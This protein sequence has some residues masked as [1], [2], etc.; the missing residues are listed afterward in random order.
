MKE[1]ALV[2]RD[3]SHGHWIGQEAQCRPQPC[4]R[5]PRETCSASPNHLEP[6]SWYSS[7]A[8]TGLVGS[9]PKL[10]KEEEMS[11]ISRPIVSRLVS[12]VHGFL[13]LMN[14]LEGRKLASGVVSS[15]PPVTRG[16]IPGFPD[17][18]SS[19]PPSQERGCQNSGSGNKQKINNL[20]FNSNYEEIS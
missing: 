4:T 20:H 1:Q 14:H 17:V 16:K 13:S 11:L 3:D 12:G 18:V 10:D 2:V 7:T 6:Q 15:V 8:C 5:P 19:V 9:K